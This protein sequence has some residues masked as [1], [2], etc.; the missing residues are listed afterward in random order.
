MLSAGTYRFSIL[1]ESKLLTPNVGGTKAWHVT[2]VRL[3]QYSKA[4]NS[5]EVKL[6]GR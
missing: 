2:F 4:Y 6:A 3:E 1:L 5:I